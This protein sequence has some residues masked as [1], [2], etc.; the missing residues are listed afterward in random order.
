MCRDS[1]SP[2]DIAGSRSEV[3]NERISVIISRLPSGRG[4]SFTVYGYVYAGGNMMTPRGGCY[5]HAFVDK[6]QRFYE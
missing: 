5:L 1:L 4:A 2:R 6:S 3:V